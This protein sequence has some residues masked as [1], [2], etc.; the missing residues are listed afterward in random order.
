M[1]I[2]VL[3][4]E[5]LCRANR[6]SRR[7]GAPSLNVPLSRRRF[8]ALADGYASLARD[9]CTASVANRV[10]AARVKN[11]VSGLDVFKADRDG[12]ASVKCVQGAP[13]EGRERS[14]V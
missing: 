1:P 2:R 3:D 6:P 14:L 11:L 12:H 13:Y 5:T 10:V 4:I 9:A 8:I 7:I